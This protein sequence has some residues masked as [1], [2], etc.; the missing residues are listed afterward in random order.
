M[1]ANRDATQLSSMLPP[2]AFMEKKGNSVKTENA[3]KTF[4][5]LNTVLQ[6][7]SFWCMRECEE[8]HFLGKTAKDHL[9]Y[10]CIYMKCSEQTKLWR[11]EANS[12]FLERVERWEGMGV[13]A[14][15]TGFP[16]EGQNVLR[17][18][19]GDGHTALWL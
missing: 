3:E 18:D 12:D 4:W 6:E 14:M 10:D 9:S 19:C 5:S 16:C 15:G 7:R 1:Q 17:L 8:A 11:Q 13:T 2:K